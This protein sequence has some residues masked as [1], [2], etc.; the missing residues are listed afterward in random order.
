MLFIL[1]RHR[2]AE[3]AA[4]KATHVLRRDGYRKDVKINT[5]EFQGTVD[6]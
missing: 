5:V 2:S 3:T 1:T 6:A 4:K